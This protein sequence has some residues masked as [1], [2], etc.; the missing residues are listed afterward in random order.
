MPIIYL[1]LLLGTFH[2][3]VVDPRPGGIGD[4]AVEWWASLAWR[5]LAVMSPLL[6]LLAGWIISNRRGMTRLFGL[7][8]RMAGDLGQFCALG[9][10]LIGRFIEDDNDYDDPQILLTYGL[11][12][13]IVFVGM[14][15]L[16]DVWVLIKVEEI[17][18]ELDR[19]DQLS[20]EALLSGIGR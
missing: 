3:I 5:I 19:L 12:G 15:V 20:G 2:I 17:T 18:R 8:L 4:I 10:F 14:L 13:V 7:W 1:F 11:V 16:R 9:T 6:T